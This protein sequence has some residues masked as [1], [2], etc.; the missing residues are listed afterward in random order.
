MNLTTIDNY[1]RF[2]MHFPTNESKQ[3][4][5]VNVIPTTVKRLA[6]ATCY[7]HRYGDDIVRQSAMSDRVGI[8]FYIDISNNVTVKLQHPVKKIF[9]PFGPLDTTLHF[10]VF[11]FTDLMNYIDDNGNI[12][13]LLTIN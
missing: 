6:D 1:T 7:Y 13:I 10:K 2:I 4:L 5:E 8:N 11:Y 12:A 9:S 3:R